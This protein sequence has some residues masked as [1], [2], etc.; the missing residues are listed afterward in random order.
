MGNPFLVSKMKKNDILLLFYS[1]KSGSSCQYI[2]TEQLRDNKLIHRAAKKVP[3]RQIK[4][5]PPASRHDASSK[6]ALVECCTK[7]LTHQRQLLRLWWILLLLLFFVVVLCCCSLLLFFVVVL[8]CCCGSCCCSCCGE[9]EEEV[10]DDNVLT[11]Y[12]NTLTGIATDMW[13][14]A[15][16]RMTTTAKY[17]L[18]GTINCKNP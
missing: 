3:A 15:M 6:L 2:G 7:K 13:T 9:E 17:G 8:C 16:T 12:Y 5:T 14:T 1:L 18:E 10:D 4:T 11:L